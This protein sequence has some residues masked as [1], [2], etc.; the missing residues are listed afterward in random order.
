[1]TRINLTIIQ[2]ESDFGTNIHRVSNIGP[3]LNLPDDV[4]KDMA[5]R[6]VKSHYINPDGIKTRILDYYSGTSEE[7]YQEVMAR[8]VAE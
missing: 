4:I 8:Y 7:E 6:Y 3:N 2:A 1:M 5:T